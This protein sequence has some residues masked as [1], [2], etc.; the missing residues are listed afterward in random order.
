MAKVNKPDSFKDYGTALKALENYDG[1]GIR[2]EG[3][4]IAIDLDHCLNNGKLDQLGEEVV[5]HFKN[6]YIEIS[7]S[8]T[9]LRIFVLMPEGFI[10]DRDTYYIKRGPV[11]VYAAGCTNRFVTV[12]GNVYQEKDIALEEASIKWLLET[13]MPRITPV[14]QASGQP[15]HTG[16]YESTTWQLSNR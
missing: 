6:T 10:Y 15:S 11:E 3:N 14:N 9:G 4:I 8:G 12:T 2:V 1:L 7:P 13:I 5:A 16:T